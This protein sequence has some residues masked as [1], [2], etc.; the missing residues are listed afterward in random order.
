MESHIVTIELGFDLVPWLG[1]GALGFF[2]LCIGAAVANGVWCAQK[3][4]SFKNWE[5]ATK[6]GKIGCAGALILGLAM[7][8][9]LN[10][11][12]GRGRGGFY[13]IN[14]SNQP[15]RV[16]V[17]SRSIDVP[18]CHWFELIVLDSR[19]FGDFRM[20]AFLGQAAVLD[21]KPLRGAYL[22]NLS[23]DW[24]VTWDKIAYVS[25]AER[26]KT[27][28][29]SGLAVF[30]PQSNPVKGRGLHRLPDEAGVIFD[31]DTPP[32]ESIPSSVGTK[33]APALKLR[34]VD[35]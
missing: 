6:V 28:F 7:I 33:S 27:G 25:K 30:Q 2:I 34:F 16:E 4:R 12:S 17:N 10:L 1:F 11:L 32:S 5:P 23:D 14:G 20:R 9:A 21:E 31:F 22:L 13:V 18:P 3:G 19:L 26:K 15:G 24:L 8:V 35:R 29:L